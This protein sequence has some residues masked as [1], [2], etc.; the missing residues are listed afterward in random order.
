MSVS[1]TT[2]ALISETEAAEFTANY[3]SANPG[4]RKA[5]FFGS[6]RLNELLVVGVIGIRIY[7]GIDNAGAPELVLVGVDA[8]GNDVLKRILDRGAPCPTECG[9]PNELNGLA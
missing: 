4:A 7:Y 1:T 3:R 6:D 2:G 5:L 8:S 9:T